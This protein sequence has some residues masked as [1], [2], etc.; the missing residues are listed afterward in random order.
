MFNRSS[1]S[2]STMPPR[3]F[4]IP[5]ITHKSQIVLPL[6]CD[7]KSNPHLRRPPSPT[8]V[9]PA[10][11]HSPPPLSDRLCK[12]SLP[13]LQHSVSHNNHRPGSTLTQVRL[14]HPR[15]LPP[16]PAMTP[17]PNLAHNWHQTRRR[18]RLRLRLH[19]RTINPTLQK[20]TIQRM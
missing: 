11:R 17:R 6:L 15:P 10:D 5:C 2:D 3:V 18:L 7:R 4:L 16:S 13:R 9:T 12:M 8:P 19:H 20:C 1:P 14:F